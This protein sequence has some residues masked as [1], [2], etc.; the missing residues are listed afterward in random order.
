MRNAAIA[1]LA[2]VTALTPVCAA[3]QQA[4][5]ADSLK[6]GAQ[7][8]VLREQPG[9]PRVELRG[10]LDRIA[11]DT[12][13]LRVTSDRFE[14]RVLDADHTL[15]VRTGRQA[16][17]VRGLAIGAAVGAMAG[18]VIGG[19]T[20]EA[21]ADCIYDPGVGATVA[22]AAVLLGFLGA[23][24]GAIIGASS[25]PETWALVPRSSGMRIGF[26]PPT[27]VGPARV[28]LSVSF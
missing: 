9:A 25:G 21:C 19:A 1:F 14:S 27:P 11:G 8:R 3:A 18:L 26:T 15:Q 16:H 13:T 6:R 28:S 10:A 23:G 22:G 5:S 7:V 12:V 2:C 17:T 20:Y 4:V 24:I